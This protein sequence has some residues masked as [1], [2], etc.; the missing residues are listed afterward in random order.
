MHLGFSIGVIAFQDASVL[1]Q[2][3]VDVAHEVGLVA[4]Y[5][6]IVCRSAFYRT[7]SFVSASMEFI[8]ALE[9]FLFHWSV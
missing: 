3:I 7:K 6:V 1:A 9:A 8:P 4:I 2:D 5:P